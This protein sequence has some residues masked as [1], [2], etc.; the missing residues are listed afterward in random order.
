MAFKT[1]MGCDV[2]IR[3]ALFENVVLS[4]GN[5]CYPGFDARIQKELQSLAGGNMKIGLSPTERKYAVWLG[6]SILSGLIS[7]HDNWVTRAEYD[8]GGAAIVHRKCF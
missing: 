7:F 1:I 6:G 8:E 5:T 3:K 2:D 4:G